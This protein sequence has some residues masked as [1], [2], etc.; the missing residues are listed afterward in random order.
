MIAAS[1]HSQ[2]PRLWV[3]RLTWMTDRF[4][5]FA[6]CMG[7]CLDLQSGSR[8]A[9]IPGAPTPA[10]VLLP[11]HQCPCPSLDTSIRPTLGRGAARIVGEAVQPPNC[12]FLTGERSLFLLSNCFF[13]LWQTEGGG[14]EHPDL[15]WDLLGLSSSLRAGGSLS[16]SAPS[17]SCSLCN[18]W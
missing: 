16:M 1:D 5:K 4:V 7:C 18:E 17:Y 12:S 11:Q 3:H 13:P 6:A 9:S 8:T 2:A 15:A 10:W 14:I